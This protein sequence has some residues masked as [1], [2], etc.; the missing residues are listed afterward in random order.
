MNLG[1]IFA[2][3]VMSHDTLLMLKKPRIIQSWRTGYLRGPYEGW[4]VGSGA[5]LELEQSAA[6]YHCH[7]D[8]HDQSIIYKNNAHLF[9]HSMQHR[10]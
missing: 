1:L 2:N 8:S 6:L 10:R 7:A 9:E 3:S 4:R 5:T